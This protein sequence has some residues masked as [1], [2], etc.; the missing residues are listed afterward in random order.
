[1][2][3]MKQL[4]KCRTCKRYAPTNHEMKSLG[5]KTIV[6]D[7]CLKF[8]WNLGRVKTSKEKLSS[9]KIV[10]FHPMTKVPGDCYE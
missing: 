9:K 5:H 8:K 1:M 7:F 2:S 3:V 6:G 4:D 10:N